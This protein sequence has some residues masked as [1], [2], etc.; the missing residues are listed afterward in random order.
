MTY[1]RRIVG[2]SPVI[3]STSPK[4]A[5]TGTAWLHLTLPLLPSSWRHAF[6]ERLPSQ[7]V[8]KAPPVFS[9]G[10]AM[11]ASVTL[12][13]HSP[14]CRSRRLPLDNVFH[15]DDLVLLRRECLLATSEA[16]P[17]APAELLGLR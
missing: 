5:S 17:D 15:V 1:D 14:S 4:P 9:P 2:A 6:R 12:K 3:S 13:R 8:P 10:M 11:I 7:R 16:N